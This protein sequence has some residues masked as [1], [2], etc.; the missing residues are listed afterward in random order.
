MIF[1]AHSMSETMNY[2]KKYYFDHVITFN[3]R[4]GLPSEFDLKQ[5]FEKF[6]ISTSI[7][8]ITHVMLRNSTHSFVLVK[9]QGNKL[10]I[11]KQIYSSSDDCALR[12]KKSTLKR[13]I[14]ALDGDGHFSDNFRC[15][16]FINIH[17][18]LRKRKKNL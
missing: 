4:S 15:F 6:K 17:R 1:I 14:I 5:Q 18:I 16:A 2:F 3:I 11:K 13:T 12:H 10:A 7:Q 8:T 9:L